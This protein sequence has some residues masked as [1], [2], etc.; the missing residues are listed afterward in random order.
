MSAS[1][2]LRL[3]NRI[4]DLGVYSVLN[5]KLIAD[6][7]DET[8]E[9]WYDLKLDVLLFFFLLCTQCCC[10]LSLRYSLTF[11]WLDWC[12]IQT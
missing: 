10:G 1:R 9:P 6:W 7:S 2:V 12:V 11:I 3:T 8:N 4:T 5:T